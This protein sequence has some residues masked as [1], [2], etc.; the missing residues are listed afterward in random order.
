MIAS[1][2]L[3][4]LA[5]PLW[6]LAC[7]ARESKKPA[8]HTPPAEPASPVVKTAAEWQELL[9]PEQYRILRQ[10]GTERPHGKAYEEFKK[11][12]QGTYHCAGCGALLF[13]SAHKFDS[14]CGWP[15]FYDPA[16]AQ[17]VQLS[18][19]Y[20]LGGVR[21]EVTCARCGGHLGHLFE[22]EGFATPTDQRFCINGGGLQ[23]VPAKAP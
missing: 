3:V 7:G 20:S 16:K 8:M 19:D 15:S 4:V 18:K 23:F 11:Q 9:T 10:A 17:N 21:T 13:S 12:G 6:L 2:T 14:G 1:R 5:L 22:G